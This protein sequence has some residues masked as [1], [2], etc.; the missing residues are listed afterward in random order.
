MQAYIVE[1]NR[2]IN[3][4]IRTFTRVSSTVFGGECGRENG[5]LT[6]T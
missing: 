3:T 1:D 4:V 6:F 2:S 5:T